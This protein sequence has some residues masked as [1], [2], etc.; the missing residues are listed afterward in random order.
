MRNGT[1]LLSPSRSSLLQLRHKSSQRKPGKTNQP[2]STSLYESISA[3]ISPQDYPPS[4]TY[5]LNTR[6]I[7]RLKPP[8]GFGSPT[9]CQNAPTRETVVNDKEQDVSP[10]VQRIT[11][12][13][14]S[15]QPGLTMEER[16]DQLGLPCNQ[17]IVA[18]VL[19]RCFKVCHL[20]LRFFNWVKSRPGFWHST[21]TYNTMLYIAGDTNQIDLMEKLLQEMEKYG[22][23]KDIKTW[24]ILIIH[25]GKT[26]RVGKALCTFQSMKISGC[27]PDYLVYKE[28]LLALCNAEKPEL[29]M[30]FYKE[31][32]SKN[33]TLNLGLFQMLVNCLV[34]LDNK[35]YIGSFRDDMTKAMGFSENEAYVCLL[36]A[37]CTKGKVKDAQEVFDEIIKKNMA[38][39]EAYEILLKG[40]CR[41]GLMEAALEMINSLKMN[42]SLSN[43]AYGFLIDGYLR[44]GDID[45]A[46]GFFTTLRGAGLVPAIS[47]YTQAM[48]HLFRGN[49]HQD[50]F[51]LFEEMLERGIQ[52]DTVAITALI[53][54]FIS[55]GKISEAWGVSKKMREKSLRLSWKAYSVF[56]KELCRASFPQEAL[57]VLE[58]MVSLC[59]N[60]SD[61]DF[62]LV[63]GCLSKVG[64][65]EL[66][67]KAENLRRLFDLCNIGVVKQGNISLNNNSA[68]LGMVLSCDPMDEKRGINNED[69]KRVCDI[70]Y[71]TREWSEIKKELERENVHYTPEMVDV[72]LRKCTRHGGVALQF[73]TWVGRRPNYKHNT[74]TYNMAIKIAGGAKD[75]QHMR[76]LYHEM[77]RNGCLIMANTWT[78]MISQYGQAGMTEMALR[79]FKEMKREGYQPDNSTYKYLILFLCEKKGRKIEEA[80]Q[81]FQ[82][83]VR[84]GFVPD[85]ET[86]GT[87]LSMLCEVGK[88]EDARRAVISLCKLGFEM[89]VAYSILVKAMCRAGRIDEALALLHEIKKI[90]CTIDQYMYGSIIHSLLRSGRAEEALNKVE[91]MKI[92]GTPCTVHVYTSLMVHFF[93]ERDPGKALEIFRKMQEVGELTVV[94]YSALI[95]GFMNNGMVK[96]AWDIYYK[97]KFKGPF[98]DFETYSMFIRSLCFAGRS[99]EAVTLILEML[100]KGIIPS[101]VN[102]KTVV[103][104]LNREG[105]H[106]LAGLVLRQKWK[107][108]RERKYLN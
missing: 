11:E 98:P 68:Q 83:M 20:A 101:T 26:G 31:M 90:G 47:S 5:Q 53:A 62:N 24:T 35:E 38:T 72:I 75:F 77:R 58:E 59:I 55:L 82:E 79:A 87:Y 41:G 21:E 40:L 92:V 39:T 2:N 85:K 81:I 103:Y 12:V 27:E 100:D 86:I 105:N 46:M 33:M 3:V 107:L 96:E 108:N 1:K 71:A 9:V 94:T 15:N 89:Q 45:K 88:I 8:Q 65:L 19:K 36:K 60:P 49:K 56:I 54:G 10:I 37:Y 18:M 28:I 69:V 13:V 102:L 32:V 61:G 80:V 34:G 14:R 17:E 78:I 25:Y 93:K 29:A 52:P 50:A 7:T 16:L 44:K 76:Y 95:R 57:K 51:K 63:I 30:E 42:S 91:E 70:L 99:K 104:G 23:E 67:N 74:C 48:Q 64:N 4:T 106:D 73:F 66:V 43:K 6:T 22:Y 97:M 84:T